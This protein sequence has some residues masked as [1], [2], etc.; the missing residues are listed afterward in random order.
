VHDIRVTDWAQ[1]NCELFESTWNESIRRFRSNF[2]YR[3]MGEAADDLRTGLMKLGGNVGEIEFHILR[4]F[5]KYAR[6]D[7]VRGDSVWNWLAVAQHHG[8][9]TRLL[10]WSYS[11]YIALHFATEELHKYDRDGAIWCVNYVEVHKLLPDALRSV[12]SDERSNAFTVEMLER[13]VPSLSALETLVPREFAVFLEP[14]SLDERI[15]NQFSIFSLMSSPAARLDE[16]LNEAHPELVRRIVIPAELK[17]EARDKLDQANITER[18][19]FPGLDG[20]TAGSVA[21]IGRASSR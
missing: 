10:D 19:L 11:P 8:V 7:A 14:P 17:W 5:K 4:N 18:V 6:Q 3:G 9:P 12:L 21:T 13:A 20:L 16:W 2:V 1:L 15:V